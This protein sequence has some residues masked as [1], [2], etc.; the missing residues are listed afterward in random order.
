MGN[1]WT[2]DQFEQIDKTI[3]DLQDDWSA[4]YEHIAEQINETVDLRPG[5]QFNAED[6][7]WR[8]KSYR[9][10]WIRRH[11]DELIAPVHDRILKTLENSMESFSKNMQDKDKHKLFLQDADIYNKMTGGYAAKKVEV[12]EAPHVVVEY[13]RPDPIEPE[14]DET[15]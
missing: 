15:D 2:Y 7:K 11:M 12:S 14:D 9:G 3:V 6:V 13:V 10:S 1:K 8:M 5:P 4:S